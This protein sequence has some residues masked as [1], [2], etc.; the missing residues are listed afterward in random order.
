MSSQRSV[1]PFR[2][3][4]SRRSPVLVVVSPP[5]RLRLRG[6][7]RGRRGGFGSRPA[8]RTLLENR[9]GRAAGGLAHAAGRHAPPSHFTSPPVHRSVTECEQQGL[10]FSA[11]SLHGEPRAEYW[12]LRLPSAGPH[13]P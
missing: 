9:G 13:A 5:S 3:L 1:E 6:L 11:A 12:G 2:C 7:A 10:L 4:T 8:W